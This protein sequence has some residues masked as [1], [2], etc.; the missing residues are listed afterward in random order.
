[1]KNQTSSPKDLESKPLDEMQANLE[2]LEATGKHIVD[3]IETREVTVMNGFGDHSFRLSRLTPELL[4][5]VKEA[6][7]PLGFKFRS[8]RR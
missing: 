4:E 2:K 5:Q 6:L 3:E 1:M 8:P 7:E